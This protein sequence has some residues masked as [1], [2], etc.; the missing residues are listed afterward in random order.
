M[1]AARTATLVA[2]RGRRRWSEII[3]AHFWI[4]AEIAKF[5]EN[6]MPVWDNFRSTGDHY[7]R[8]SAHFWGC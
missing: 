4:S 6:R 1:R 8:P 2:W 5:P 7:P 3:P